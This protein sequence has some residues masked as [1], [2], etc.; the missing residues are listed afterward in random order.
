MGSTTVH[1]RREA[2]ALSAHCFTVASLIGD[3]S[4]S[5]QQRCMEGCLDDI[6][7]CNFVIIFASRPSSSATMDPGSGCVGRVIFADL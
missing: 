7:I 6:V 1:V 4:D 2:Q 5:N 3:Q